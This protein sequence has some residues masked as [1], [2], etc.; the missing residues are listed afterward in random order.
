MEGSVMPLLKG[1]EVSSSFHPF[2]FPC[3]TESP[4]PNCPFCNTRNTFPQ[5]YTAHLP[6][7]EAKKRHQMRPGFVANHPSKK[8]IC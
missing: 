5:H 7:P 2:P 3:P 6:A 4:A 1:G 8:T